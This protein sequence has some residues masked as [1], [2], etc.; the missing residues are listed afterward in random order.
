MLKQVLFRYWF[1]L[2]NL[3]IVQLSQAQT[4]NERSDKAYAG[5]MH[6]DDKDSVILLN[7]LVLYRLN[8]SLPRA[9]Q[10]AYQAVKT[11]ERI[12]NKPLFAE[13]LIN[14]SSVYMASSQFDSARIALEQ[15]GKI[16][17]SLSSAATS[18][19]YYLNLGRL[20]YKQKEYKEA[21]NFLNKAVIVSEKEDNHILSGSAYLYLANCCRQLNRK[22][23]F[24][25]FLNKSDF[26]FQKSNDPVQSGPFLIS[27]GIHFSDMGM[28]EKA[29][30]TFVSAIHACEITADS[31][32]LGYL[33]CNIAG[34]LNNKP[35]D[36]NSED[37]LLTALR[38]FR[39]LKNDRAI[40][41]AL[42]GIGLRYFSGKEYEKALLYFTEAAPLKEKSLDW[43]GACFVYCNITE[44]HIALKQPDKATLTIQSADSACKSAGDKL[45][46]AV[47]LQS[48]GRYLMAN[49][50]FEQALDC[51]EN[52][53]V[54]AREILNQNI[55]SE[56][57]LAISE[58]YEAKGNHS[59]ALEYY[60]LYTAGKDSVLGESMTQSMA[61]LKMRY[62]DE[63]NKTQLTA[64]NNNKMTS[65]TGRYYIFGN[66]AIIFILLL[67][68]LYFF[69]RLK[70]KATT[71][72]RSLLNM[73]DRNDG[74]IDQSKSEFSQI[75][76]DKATKPMPTKEMRNEIWLQ[77]TDL[78]EIEKIY[79]EN[80]LSL[81]ELSHKL[82][83]N[84]T[85]LSKVI[86][87]VTHQN[88][89]NY[90]NHYRIDEACRL[91]SE[92]QNHHL[93]IEGIAQMVG[94]KSKS[95]FN[96]AFKKNMHITPSEFLVLQSIE[97]EQLA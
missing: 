2:F 20:A 4:I 63:K 52:S 5:L 49:Q 44:L 17:G 26:H 79:L 6:A 78:M 16:S 95:A 45:S 64:S 38:I 60:K 22:Q 41:Y 42:N 71:G 37:Y 67:V 94:F 75:S 84:T 1:L 47:F 72:F 25:D 93:T 15:A 18:G 87:M 54:A 65:E 92:P 68:S 34:I 85:Y 62:E 57:L 13:S 74:I 48:K 76:P 69:F 59:V 81:A 51:F 3:S 19:K 30:E 36:I 40:G 8:D 58:L 21:I 9:K 24:I 50:S 31:L 61:A 43:Q 27:L 97:E 80:D 83:T 10:L 33:Y 28:I 23:E 35:S 32:Y 96:N 46:L 77:L 53:I 11:A 39:N 7:E 91:L 90:L 56:N 66:S 14:L 12:N 55:V 88:F 86:N 89:C 29:S 82:N 73:N 70:G